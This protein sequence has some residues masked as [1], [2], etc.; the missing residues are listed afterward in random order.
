M[1][2]RVV[3]EGYSKTMPNPSEL[4]QPYWDGL[5]AGQVKVQQCSDCGTRQWYPREMCHH[6]H[7]F[8]VGWAEVDP[9]GTVYSY[10]VQHQKTGS[11]FDEDLPYAVLVVELDGAPEVRLTGRLVTDPAEAVE[12]GTPVVGEFLEV[13]PDIT[14]L[15]W[16]LA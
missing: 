11:K 4:D 14:I 1:V 2:N 12:I 16:R 3:A 15:N 6:C 9:R 10:A 13:N 5:R 8:N 7:S